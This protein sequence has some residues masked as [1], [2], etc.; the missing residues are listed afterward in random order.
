MNLF[1][2]MSYR[3]HTHNPIAAIIM[4]FS[5]NGSKGATDALQHISDDQI[6]NAMFRKKNTEPEE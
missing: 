5:I 4:G 3:K 1:T 2:H 6:Y